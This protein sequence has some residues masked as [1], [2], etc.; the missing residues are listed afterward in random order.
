MFPNPANPFGGT[1]PDTLSYTIQDSV[2]YFDF[3]GIKTGDTDGSAYPGFGNPTPDD[4]SMATLTLP[5]AVLLPG[6][7]LEIPLRLAGAGEWLGLQMG[8]HFDPNFLEIE[9]LAPSN[10]PGMDESSFASPQPGTLNVVWFDPIPQVIL[11][12]ENV[13]TLRVKALA[14]L[15]LSE[16]IFLAKE[17]FDSEGYTAE[18]ATQKLQLHFTERTATVGETAVFPPQPNPTN[19]GATVP[20]RLSKSETVTLELTEISGKRLFLKHI[21]LDAGAH[22]LE[23][24]AAA[25]SQTGVYLWRVRA[26]EMTESGK[27]VRM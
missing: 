10:L 16:H 5:D 26:G 25:F 23:I 15:R 7:T 9:A 18:E 3:F 17:K 19:A 14:P 1:W 12:D 27:L 2:V 22:L 24:P 21:T 4:R 20:L 11:P 13:L 6:E 8:L